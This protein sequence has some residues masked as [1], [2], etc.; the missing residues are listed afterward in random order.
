MKKENMQIVGGMLI[1]AVTVAGSI[2]AS[3]ITASAEIKDT[4][5]ETKT[6]LSSSISVDRQ[7]IATLNE[8]ITTIK[9]DNAEIKRDIKDILKLIK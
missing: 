3:K 2:F 9:T 5:N 4:I 1:A 7:N 8:A 6:E